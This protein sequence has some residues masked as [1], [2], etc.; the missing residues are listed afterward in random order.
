MWIFEPWFPTSDGGC[1][2]HNYQAAKI[3]SL[4]CYNSEMGV[5][6]FFGGAIHFINCVFVNNHFCGYEGK[7][8]KEIVA[9]SETQGP[10]IIN[11]VIG[12]NDYYGKLARQKTKYAIIVPYEEG[13]I[14]KNVTFINFDSSKEVSHCLR[15]TDIVCISGPNNGGFRV[16]TQMFTF[17]N[18]PNRVSIRWLHEFIFS[19]MDGSLTG[20]GPN[21]TMVPYMDYLLWDHCQNASYFSPDSKID[22]AICDGNIS[23]HRASWNAMTPT[24]LNGK[25]VIIIDCETNETAPSRFVDTRI[26]S[27][28]GWMFIAIDGRC[29]EIRF[30]N[31]EH[32]TNISY[33]ALYST[34][35]VSNRVHHSTNISYS[36]LYSI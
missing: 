16:I 26:I 28:D 34:Y 36:A 12:A 15:V 11:M 20:L 33:S 13:L 35:P 21:S 3:D 17:I 5:Q 24:S 19:D 31:G 27:S 22:A 30:I 4:T 29:Y 8:L 14:I 18:S 7:W 23:F 1:N 10:M 32:F 25:K 9:F 6:V 2:S